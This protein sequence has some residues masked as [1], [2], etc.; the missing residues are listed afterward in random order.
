MRKQA[1]VPPLPAGRFKPWNVSFRRTSTCLK[2]S[3]SSCFILFLSRF[4][5]FFAH[6]ELEEGE[7]DPNDL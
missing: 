4:S 7:I 2:S 6:Q 5:R 1:A 3:R